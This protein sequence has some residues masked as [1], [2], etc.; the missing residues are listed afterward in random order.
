MEGVKIENGDWVGVAIP[1]ALPDEWAGMDDDT[2]NEMLRMMDLGIADPDG[3]EEYYSLRPQDKERWVGNIIL[4]YAFDN[5]EHGKNIG[6]AKKILQSWQ[7]NGLLEEFEYRS[8][9]Q[10]KDRKGVRSTGRVGA[11]R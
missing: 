8:A 6:Q 4:T 2:V 10:R 11:Q 1:F 5:P 9:K 3:N 7:N